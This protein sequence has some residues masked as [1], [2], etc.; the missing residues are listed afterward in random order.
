MKTIGE[1]LPELAEE[2][3]RLLVKVGRQDLVS[4]VRGLPIV[5][6]CR[7]HQ[8]DCG[9][10]DTGERPS[11][12]STIDLYSEECFLALDTDGYSSI[13]HVEV[14]GRP[15]VKKKLDAVFGQV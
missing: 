15:D 6:R 13:V 3:E 5:G 2:L 12:R 9:S 7:C 14:L 10:F 1:V 8:E 11:R 4:Q